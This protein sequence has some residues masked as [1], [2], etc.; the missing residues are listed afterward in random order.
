[1][2]RSRVWTGFAVC[3]ILMQDGCGLQIPQDPSGSLERLSGETIRVG[4]STE[5]HLVEDSD[6][7]PTGSLVELVQGFASEHD[8]QVEWSWGSEETLVKALEEAKIDLAIGGCTDQTPWS[9]RAGVT[10]GYSE[11]P[12][13]SERSLVMLVPLGENRFLSALESYLDEELS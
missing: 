10:R 3:V 1:M 7:G 9:H 6:T 11:I 4:A 12:G 8:A 2:A 13:A 5:E